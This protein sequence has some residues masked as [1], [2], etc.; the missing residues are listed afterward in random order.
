MLL[1]KQYLSMLFTAGPDFLFYDGYCYHL[2][3]L[4]LT[5]LFDVVDVDF[6]AIPLVVSMFYFEDTSTGTF[7]H[8]SSVL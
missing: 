8:A 7:A 4:V 1:D 3:L 2:L 5:M 6:D